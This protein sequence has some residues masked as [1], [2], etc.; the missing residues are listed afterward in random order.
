[1]PEFNIEDHLKD[2]PEVPV[3]PSKPLTVEEG[4]RIITDEYLSAQ[5]SKLLEIDITKYPC[6]TCTLLVRAEDRIKHYLMT[7]Y[8]TSTEDINI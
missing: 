6:K 2:D 8:K 4:R 5:K 3:I 7:H 1:M